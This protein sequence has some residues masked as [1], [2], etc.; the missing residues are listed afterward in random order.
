MTDWCWSI[1]GCPGNRQLRCVLMS[2][3]R[4]TGSPAVSNSHRR[5]PTQG[6]SRLTGATSGDISMAKQLVVVMGERLNGKSRFVT[7]NEDLES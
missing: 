3:N 6:K 2:S 4:P 5:K 7:E 1:L